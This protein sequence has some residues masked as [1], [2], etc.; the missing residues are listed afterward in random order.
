MSSTGTPTVACEVLDK[1]LSLRHTRQVMRQ[2]QRPFLYLLCLA[3][4][5]QGSTFGVVLS[6]PCPMEATMA[7]STVEMPGAHDCCNDADAAARTGKPCK[8]G[9]DCAAGSVAMLTASLA[10]PVF[11]QACTGSPCAVPTRAGFQ[12]GAIWRPPTSL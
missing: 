8:T 5:V 12:P 1:R 7:A 3:L 4:P 10:A 6:A 9:Q 11:P 2:L